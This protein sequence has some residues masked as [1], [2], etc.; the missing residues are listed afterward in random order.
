MPPSKTAHFVQPDRSNYAKA[1]PYGWIVEPGT[2]A[3]AMES[4]PEFKP[5]DPD[6]LEAVLGICKSGPPISLA[7]RH[8]ELNY[9]R[10]SRH[11]DSTGSSW[12]RGRG[13]PWLTTAIHGTIPR[14]TREL[15]HR[16]HLNGRHARTRNNRRVH[17]RCP[18]PTRRVGIPIAARVGYQGFNFQPRIKPT[19]KHQSAAVSGCCLA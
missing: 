5:A 1:L 15:L 7:D 4:T 18:F 19:P 2:P 12:I 14:Q 9:G 6:P 17:R 16:L 8:D 11:E 13:S 10:N 3:G